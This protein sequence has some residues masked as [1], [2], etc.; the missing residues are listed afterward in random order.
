MN[1]NQYGI[2][3]MH[4]EGYDLPIKSEDK[5]QKTEYTWW[6]N[7]IFI[8]FLSSVLSCIIHHIFSPFLQVILNHG[9]K[10]PFQVVLLQI[11]TIVFAEILNSLHLLCRQ[12]VL[13]K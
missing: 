2:K 7:P 10:L 11:C 9:N 1:N 6:S 13:N 3:V 4:E 8:V 12:I 5:F